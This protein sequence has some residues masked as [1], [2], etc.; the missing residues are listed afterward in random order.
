MKLK[1]LFKKKEVTTVYEKIVKT[2]LEVE[3]AEKEEKKEKDALGK[4]APKAIG[5]LDMVIAFDTTG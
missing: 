4:V 5:V 2:T 3:D 1:D